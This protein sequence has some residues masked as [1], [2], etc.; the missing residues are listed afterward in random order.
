MSDNR[1]AK[2]T[3]RE[4]YREDRK[5]PLDPDNYYSGSVA[6]DE[7]NGQI[8]MKSGGMAVSMS[9]EDWVKLA[10]FT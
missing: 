4:L 7:A 1:A 8:V 10:L 3:E 5:E 9:I 2:N 6:V